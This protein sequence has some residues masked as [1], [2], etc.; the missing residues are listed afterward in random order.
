MRQASLPYREPALVH[1]SPS[2]PAP[3][4]SPAR[5]RARRQLMAMTRRA[6]SSGRCS[7]DGWLEILVTDFPQLVDLVGERDLEHIIALSMRGR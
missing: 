5:S 1:R 4:G 3:E 2:G 7:A 6:L